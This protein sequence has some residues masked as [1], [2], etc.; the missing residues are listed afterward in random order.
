MSRPSTLSGR[1]MPS[2]A[3]NVGKTSADCV[4]RGDAC[5]RAP[6][7][8]ESPEEGNAG[9]RLVQAAAMREGIALTEE[10]A[11]VG[12]QDDVRAVEDGRFLE[13]A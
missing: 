13:A 11:V 10:L 2:S 8:G 7:A 5:A 3:S 12:E 1:A 4:G 9:L 6:V